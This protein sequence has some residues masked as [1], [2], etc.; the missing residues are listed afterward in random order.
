MSE[1]ATITEL[2]E[3]ILARLRATISGLEIASFPDDPLNYRL[4][5]QRGALLVCF[6]G[7]K[8]GASETLDE[9]TQL[10]TLTFD[11]HV[12]TRQ[13][14]GHDGSYRHL[15]AA[16]AALTGHVVDGFDPLYAVGE[17]FLGHDDGVWAFALTMAAVAVATEVYEEDLDELIDEI[18]G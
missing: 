18:Y 3:G 7:A 4:K 9:V 11:I 17:A 6:R 2:E 8:Y 5:H 13:L 1:W 14:Q 16:R 12:I 15:E 10:R